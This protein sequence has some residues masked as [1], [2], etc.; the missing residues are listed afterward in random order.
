M[1]VIGTCVLIFLQA[2]PFFVGITNEISAQEQISLIPV[3]AHM[4]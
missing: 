3:L 1:Q 4:V 2:T